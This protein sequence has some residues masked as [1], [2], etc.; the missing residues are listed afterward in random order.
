VGRK[1]V[2]PKPLLDA[3]TIALLRK[4]VARGHMRQGA[5]EKRAHTHNH[6]VM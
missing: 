2:N 5:N 1:V 4:D 6:V 3:P